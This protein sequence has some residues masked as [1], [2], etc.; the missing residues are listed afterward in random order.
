MNKFFSRRVIAVLSLIVIIIVVCINFSVLN[1]FFF[2]DD[3]FHLNISK[4]HTLKEFLSFFEFRR[5]IIQYRP[6]TMQ[7]YFYINF[8]LFGFN[9]LGFRIENLAFLFGSYFLI[10]KVIERILQDKFVAFL[11]ATFWVLSSVY[12]MSIVWI[13]AAWLFVGT[14]FWLLTSLFFLNFQKKKK[15]IFYIFSIISFL[16]TIGSFEFSVTWP[17]IFAFYYFYVLRNTFFKTIRIF[18][19]FF[20]LVSI[21]LILRMFFIKAPEILEYK[22]SFDF[23]SIKTLFWYLLGSFN[24]P[25]EFKKQIVNHLLLFNP[26]FFSEYWASVFK[27]FISGFLVFLLAILIPIIQ[28][29]RKH[30]KANFRIIAFS[31]FWFLTGISPVLFLPNHYFVMYLIL[32]SVGIYFLMAYLLSSFGKK[33]FIIP[34]LI[35]WFFSSYNTISFYKINSYQIEAQKFAR[36]FY[37]E[38]KNEFPNLPKN[39]IVYYPLESSQKQLALENQEAIKAIYNDSSLSIYYNKEDLLSSLKKGNT[40]KVY[41]YFPK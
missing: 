21:Y 38:I 26:K 18:A 15:N 33:I 1:Y 20:L 39:S 30:L 7:L 12:F 25:E 16:L 3:F 9:T 14:F 35:I 37:T 41:I 29:F 31:I 11:T 28:I 23:V 22:M 4:A 27:T 36:T 32:P 13:G 6:I 17:F 5:D 8:L 24:I 19:P 2:Q 34:T 10:L 40:G